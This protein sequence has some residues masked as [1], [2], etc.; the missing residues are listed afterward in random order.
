ML[1]SSAA[2]VTTLWWRKSGFGATARST[3][4]TVSLFY[5]QSGSIISYLVQTYGAGKF[6]EFIAAFK[7]DTQEGAIK[8]VYGMDQLAFENAWRK[9][10]GLVAVTGGNSTAGNTEGI[11]TI[12][13]FGSGQSSPAA[14]PVSGGGSAGSQSAS[15]DGGGSG[16]ILLIGGGV[17]IALLVLGGGAFAL[18]RRKS[19]RFG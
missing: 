13:P 12:V 9:S 2:R 11:P 4:D 7:N 1:R 14:T 19:S 5:G 3:A 17:V 8:K 10:I 6:A 18:T 15:D 16:G